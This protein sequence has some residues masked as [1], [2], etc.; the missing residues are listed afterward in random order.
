MFVQEVFLYS[1]WLQIELFKPWKVLQHNMPKKTI[2]FLFSFLFL[3]DCFVDK[4]MTVED[5]VKE[6]GRTMVGIGE[7]HSGKSGD[8]DFFSVDQAKAVISYLKIRYFFFQFQ[9]CLYSYNN[10]KGSVSKMRWSDF[11]RHVCTL[12]QSP[13]HKM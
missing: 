6:L 10:I 12:P 9:L 8:L 7:P 2:T 1:T 13:T 4:H 11:I 3:L 5:N